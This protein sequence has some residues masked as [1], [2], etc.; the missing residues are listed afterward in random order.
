MTFDQMTWLN[1]PPQA[2]LAGTSLTVTTA[3]QTDFWR[4]THYGYSRHSGHFLHHPV[5]GDF[6]AEVTI[7]ARYETQYDQ[8][9]L[10]LWI[11]ETRW[12][13]AGVEF[14]DGQ[15][16]FSTVITND[17]S[18][19]SIFALPFPADRLSLRL[20]RQADALWV[21]LRQPDGTWPTTR[22]GYLEAGPG[23]VGPMTC[24]PS[25][26]GFTVQFHDYSCGPATP[27][28]S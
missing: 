2:S 27:G 16:I 28:M 5:P 4:K 7:A 20:T 6:T 23:L 3:P 24:S 18:D 14:T 10:M 26:K 13:K 12:V 25:E 17:R 11:D 19:W 9:G 15:C 1:P 22:L 8:A 21:Q